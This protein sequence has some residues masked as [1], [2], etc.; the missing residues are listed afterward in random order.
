VDIAIDRE[1]KLEIDK[2]LLPEDAQFKGYEDV[3]VQ[4]IKLET[5]IVLFRKEKYYSN[6]MLYGN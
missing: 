3:V 6:V 5:D 2:A 1:Q 4:D